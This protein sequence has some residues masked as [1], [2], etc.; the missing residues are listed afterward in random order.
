MLWNYLSTFKIDYINLFSRYSMIGC[1]LIVDK[2]DNFSDED[3]TEILLQEFQD[4]AEKVKVNW[5]LNFIK[6]L[7]ET[8][9]K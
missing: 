3:S 1:I 7:H 6:A 9:N 5:S 4:S 8:S 2:G